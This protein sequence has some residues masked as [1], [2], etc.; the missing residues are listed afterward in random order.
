[1]ANKEYRNEDLQTVKEH[2]RFAEKKGSDN[3]IT[4][5]MNGS[6]APNMEEVKRLGKDMQYVKTEGELE[7]EG[8]V[9]DPIQ[10][11]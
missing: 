8:L 5:I 3:P 1:M 2:E 4:E 10:K 11:D 6:M 9:S 7:K